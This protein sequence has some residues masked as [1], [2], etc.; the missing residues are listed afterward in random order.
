MPLFFGDLLAATPT[1][2]GEERA[3]YV[4]L[5]AYQWTAGP[6]PDDVKRLAKMCQYDAKRF[7]VL[8]QTVGAKFIKH[9]EGLVNERLERHREKS[10]KL[11][12]KNAASGKKGAEAKWR[13][14]GERHKS[15]SGETDGER[16]Q[17]ANGVTHGNPSHPIPSHSS[18][19]SV[20]RTERARLS[21]D[22]DVWVQA[23]YPHCT[24]R[25]AWSTALH[26]AGV[27]VETGKAT[28]ADL[29]RRVAGYRAFVDGEGVSGPE[30]V[31][32]PQNFF[33]LHA[34]DAPWGKE[35]AAPKSKAQQRMQGNIDSTQAWLRE[36]EERDRAAN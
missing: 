5:L 32:T 12:E 14:H 27:I 30:R 4:L 26:D 16:Q 3:L 18:E 2:D 6:L 24:G 29:R 13:K 17:S 34:E 25:R 15:A 8:W 19:P 20:L 11:S 10:V 9:P 22:F 21:D 33:A 31:Y 7:S 36:Q 35:W 1:W 28:E 23:E